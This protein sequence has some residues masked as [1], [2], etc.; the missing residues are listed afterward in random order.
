VDSLFHRMNS[1]FGQMS[2]L[3]RAPGNLPQQ[4]EM[5]AKTDIGKR[6]MPEIS[7]YSLIFSL[8]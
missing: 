7:S 3:F 2:S 5:L 1:L 6:K 4:A 8:F